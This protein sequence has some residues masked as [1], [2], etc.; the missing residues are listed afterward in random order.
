MNSGAYDMAKFKANEKNL[1]EKVRFFQAKEAKGELKAYMI[2]RYDEAKA[3]HS[4]LLAMNP[5][6]AA[7]LPSAASPVA[8]TIA[9]LAETMA[10][11]NTLSSAPAKTRKRTA[12]KV[13]ATRN[14]AALPSP[15]GFNPPPPNAPTRPI[16][17]GNY[18]KNGQFKE[19]G[20]LAPTY[21]LASGM[22]FNNL[23]ASKT[24]A[25]RRQR[26]LTPIYNT[27]YEQAHLD[28]LPL[29]ELYDPY[30]GR[31]FRPEENPLP[32]IETAFH[33]LKDILKKAHKKAAS[34]RKRAK[35]SASRKTKTV[36]ATPKATAKLENFNAG[37]RIRI[38]P[39]RTAKKTKK[40]V[41]QLSPIQE[42][43][44]F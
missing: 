44:N 30:T 29:P 35:K 7:P 26:S 25:T 12:K 15:V 40:R 1:R 41:L 3:M 2:P 11:P 16:P 10:F 38:P 19:T 23:A 9:N 33:E 42:V 32:P 8:P 4:K 21:D 14:K 22:S 5:G 36:K 13:N 27:F 31:K 39:T 6:A 43:G 37:L 34:L 20:F 28:F 24:K 18:N 17:R